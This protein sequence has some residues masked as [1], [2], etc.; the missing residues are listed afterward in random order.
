MILLKNKTFHASRPCTGTAR[1]PRHK[2]DPGDII[3]FLYLM[4]LYWFRILDFWTIGIIHIIQIM[5]STFGPGDIISSLQIIIAASIF[6]FKSVQA[7]CDFHSGC[8]AFK[9]GFHT[10]SC[11]LSYCPNVHTCPGVYWLPPRS[12]SHSVHLT[13]FMKVTAL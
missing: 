9:I 10:L 12:Q 4:M 8:E 6:I 7:Q 2:R 5:K 13:I 3:S 11:P 1:C